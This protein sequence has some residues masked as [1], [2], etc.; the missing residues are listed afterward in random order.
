MDHNGRLDTIVAIHQPP[1][2]PWFGLVD[3]IARCDVFIILDNVQYSRRGFLHRALMSAAGGPRYLSLPVAARGHQQ[4][5]LTIGDAS[6]VDSTAA[7][8]HFESMRHRYGKRPGWRLWEDRLRETLCAHQHSLIDMNTK[9][10]EWTLEAFRI[11]P[12]IL[13]A[14]HLASEG[15]KSQL[16][17]SLTN[18]AGGDCYLSGSGARQYMDD[19]VFSRAG[20]TVL[21]QH[22]AHP[23]FQQ[24][25]QGEFQPGCFAMEWIFEEPDCAADKYHRHLKETGDSVP[26]CLAEPR[27]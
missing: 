5:G 16:M 19:A 21:Y 7:A 15:V 14:S 23:V 24:S 9:T 2:F 6:L 1:Y 22:F 18:A 4:S 11:A 27:S 25:H 10:L 26:R 17:L 13:R 8:R 20:C 12:K 3:K